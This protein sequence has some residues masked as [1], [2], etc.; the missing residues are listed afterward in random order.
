MSYHL[1]ELESAVDALYDYL[2]TKAHEE[3]DVERDVV[4][5]LVHNLNQA[6]FSWAY[7]IDGA[8]VEVVE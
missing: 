2:E 4:M 8:R 6:Y 5:H 7:S 1:A 3:R